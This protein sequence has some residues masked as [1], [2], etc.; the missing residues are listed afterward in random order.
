[1]EIRGCQEIAGA[2]HFPLEAGTGHAQTLSPMPLKSEPG[3]IPGILL[4]DLS[5]VEHG[6]TKEI[7]GWMF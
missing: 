6:N 3:V 2:T 1:M 4:S 5:I 7:S